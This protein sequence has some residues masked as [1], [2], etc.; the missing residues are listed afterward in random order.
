LPV[1]QLSKVVQAFHDHS[2]LAEPVTAM[3]TWDDV[4]R[5]ALAL[6]ETSEEVR[7]TNLVWKVRTKPFAWERP[8]GKGDRAAL[9]DAAPDGDILA[10]RIAQIELREALIASDP[11]V[12]FTIPHF[13]G[14]PAVLVRLGVVDERELTEALGEAWLCMAPKRLADD[15]LKAREG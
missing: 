11:A 1:K 13:S 15:F 4:R 9:G 3:A 12:Y 7:R 8:L 5:I 2:T 10:V 6:P 14:F